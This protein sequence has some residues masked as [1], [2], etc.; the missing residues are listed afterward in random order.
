[1]LNVELVTSKVR[2]SYAPAQISRTGSVSIED[3]RFQSGKWELG[4]RRLKFGRWKT[5]FI[6]VLGVE[7][8]S[9]V[10]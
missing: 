1:M 9:L 10:Y 6:K 2:L 4:D 5:I 7:V 8:L 3:S